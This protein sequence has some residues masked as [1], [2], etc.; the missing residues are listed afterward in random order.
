MVKQCRKLKEEAGQG[1]E[2]DDNEAVETCLEQIR[3]IKVGEGER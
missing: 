1:G 2:G 3:K